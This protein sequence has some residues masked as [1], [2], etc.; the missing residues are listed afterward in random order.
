MK[1]VCVKAGGFSYIK[2]KYHSVSISSLK[3][4]VSA[5]VFFVLDRIKT[6]KTKKGDDMAF[7][8]LSDD[9]GEIEGTVFPK[10]FSECGSYLVP[11]KMFVATVK[12]ENR[13]GKN[14]VIV[15]NVFINKE[16]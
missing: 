13:N 2:K 12:M 10:V 14:Q 5:N 1:A 6:I 11:G 3:A 8:T 7:I 9:T 4:G 16:K 15:D